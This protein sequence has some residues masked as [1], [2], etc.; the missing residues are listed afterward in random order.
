MLERRLGR[1]PTWSPWPSAPLRASS[2]LIAVVLALGA[3]A[4]A[5]AQETAPPP[6]GDERAA[7]TQ[8]SSAPAPIDADSIRSRISQVQQ[9]TTLGN[10]MKER[11]VGLLNQALLNLKDVDEATAATNRFKAQLEQ[12]GRELDALQAQ[13]ASQPAP[14]D[15]SQPPDLPLSELEQRL[16]DAEAALSQAQLAA[17]QDDDAL[18]RRTAATV[19]LPKQLLGLREELARL[20]TGDESA[21]AESPDEWAQAQRIERQTK[22]R[23]LEASIAAAEAEMRFYQGAG[24]WLTAKRD[25]SARDAA[26][27]EQIVKQ[28]REVVTRRRAQQ[29]EAAAAQAAKAQAEAAKLPPALQQIAEENTALAKQRAEML[30]KHE[31]LQARQSEVEKLESTLRAELKD[32]K[33]LA[34]AAQFSQAVGQLLRSQRALLP[35]LRVH[36]RQIRDRQPEVSEI[37]FRSLDYTRRRIAL[38]DDLERFVR[39]VMQRVRQEV[40]AAE[41]PEAEKEARGLYE[42]Q[43]DLLAGA[44]DDAEGYLKTLVSLDETQNRLIRTTEEFSRFIDER[45]LWTQNA[46][47]LS[48]ED[49]ARAREALLWCLRPEAWGEV[50]GTLAAALRRNP[51]LGPSVA[52]LLLLLALHGNLVRRLLELGQRAQRPL[53][54]SMGETYRAALLTLLLA[55]PVPALLWLVGWAVAA[56]PEAGAFSRAVGAALQATGGMLLPLLLVVYVARQHGLAGAFFHWPVRS[57]RVLRRNVL[58]MAILLAPITFVTTLLDV[59][60]DDLRRDS[61]GRAMYLLGLVVRAAFL[62]RLLH[63]RHGV[64]YESTVRKPRSWPHRLRHVWFALGIGVPGL[65]AVATIAGYSYTAS[66]L[67]A[68][69]RST[70]LVFGVA[71]VVYALLQRW[72]L[73]MRRRIAIAQSQ[74]RRAAAAEIAAAVEAGAGGTA[75]ALGEE[76]VDISEL[77]SQTQRLLKSGVAFGVAIGLWFI[78]VNLLPALSLLRQVTLWDGVTLADLLAAA[79][80]ALMMW[81]AVKNIPGLLEIAVLQ[82]LP[83][84]AGARYAA[85]TVTRYMLVALGVT[86]T[87]SFLGL[88]WSQIQWLVAAVSVGLGFGLQE[89]FANFVSGLILLFERPVRLGDTVTI[90]NVSGRV[91]RIRIR[92]TTITDWDRKDLIIP[93]RDL[94]TGQI[95]NWTL[96]NQLLRIVIPVGVAY[97]SDTELVRSLL[98]RSTK[99]S[100][101]ITDDPPPGVFFVGFGESALNF[102]LQAFVANLSDW[103]IARDEL[104]TAIDNSFRDAGIEIAFPQTDVHIRTIQQA[105]PVVQAQNPAGPRP[106]EE[107]R[108]AASADAGPSAGPGREGGTGPRRPEKSLQ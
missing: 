32:V 90:G 78:W 52:V 65:M 104:L 15:V 77:N 94:V 72:L 22:R 6:A 68:Q 71:V 89:I 99:A 88:R 96:T 95:I 47:P 54:T 10:E 85:T 35:E 33:D 81:I 24:E 107:A 92:A 21:G 84:D 36:R 70:V 67:G 86:I 16:A 30:A 55:L 82:H 41:W 12:A 50:A 48:L 105:L 45:I 17:T 74:K 108:R 53:N 61:L 19:E 58:W 4:P 79:A 63:P 101:R 2:G 76:Q 1:R 23:A 66:H 29:A 20:T 93:N 60:P 106:L 37:T 38:A 56:A 18:K 28:L 91:T 98:L 8:P 51:A 39:S 100:S 34:A 73:L 42:T 44:S 11:I 97:G 83:V 103:M 9:L 31:A 14:V 102:E 46:K 43:R 7:Q 27:A 87:C 3:K 57:I 69:L 26:R 64:L 49:V 40:P 75:E 80:A 25:K 13:L 5:G 62:A 59:Q